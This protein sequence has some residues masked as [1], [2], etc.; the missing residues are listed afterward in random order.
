MN[1][2][3]EV[4][5]EVFSKDVWGASA[6][7]GLATVTTAPGK[8]LLIDGHYNKVD[9]ECRGKLTAFVSFLTAGDN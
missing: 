1:K 5:K 6:A 7:G 9:V 2:G 8:A 3:G 4:S